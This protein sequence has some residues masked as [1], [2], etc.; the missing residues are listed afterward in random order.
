[1]PSDANQH[2]VPT[3]KCLFL[4]GYH[5]V[6]QTFPDIL[7]EKLFCVRVLK[8]AGWLLQG[9][10]GNQRGTDGSLFKSPKITRLFASPE[11]PCHW[12]SLFGPLCLSPVLLTAVALCTIKILFDMALLLLVL[13][14]AVL[15]FDQNG[16]LF[17]LKHL[18]LLTLLQVLCLLCSRCCSKLIVWLDIIL[19]L[20]YGFSSVSVVPLGLSLPKSF[21]WTPYFTFTCLIASV[22]LLFADHNTRCFLSAL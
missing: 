8:R 6:L 21:W 15:T 10:T 22:S 3:S 9:H 2:S 14:I 18:Q 7:S 20:T 16:H 12:A 11:S 4:S 5:S 13:F 17:L 19:S 1:M